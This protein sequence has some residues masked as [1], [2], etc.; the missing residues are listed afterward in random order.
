MEPDQVQQSYRA[1]ELSAIAKRNGVSPPNTNGIPRAHRLTD[2][3][4]VS[5]R[6][7]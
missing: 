3:E 5:A 4:N 6:T 7:W 1:N 2:S